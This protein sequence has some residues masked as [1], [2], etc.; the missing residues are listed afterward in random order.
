[1]DLVDLGVLAA[2]EPASALHQIVRL[3]LYP[4]P[5]AV[6]V[7]RLLRPDMV[8]DEIA[9]GGDRFVGRTSRESIP[10]RS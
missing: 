10:V 2:A 7:K 4:L 8:V 1:M 3:G 6:A 9:T 5:E